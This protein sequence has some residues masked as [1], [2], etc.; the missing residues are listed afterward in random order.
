[1][2]IAAE[3]NE[4]IEVSN[5]INVYNNG[6][7]SVY[8]QNDVQYGKIVAGWLALTGDV[9]EMPAFGVSL[10]KETRNAMSAGLWVEFVFDKQYVH[11]EMP[12]EK[13]LVKVEKQSQGFNVIRYNAKEGYSGRCYYFDL[14]G[15]DMANF[16]NIL[17]NL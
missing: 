15:R 10:D 14:L 4:I 13:L 8:G 12:F 16:Y 2:F 1:M 9:H 7:I 11:N 17:C 3:L 6:V 5:N